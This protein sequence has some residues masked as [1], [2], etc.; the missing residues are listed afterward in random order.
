MSDFSTPQCLFLHLIFSDERNRSLQLRDEAGDLLC[1]SLARFRD[2]CGL[3]VSFISIGKPHHD[4]LDWCGFV[5]RF[6]QVDASGLLAKLIVVA[7]GLLQ[8]SPDRFVN[9]LVHVRLASDLPHEL[10]DRSGLLRDLLLHVTLL[11]HEPAYDVARVLGLQVAQVTLDSLQSTLCLRPR[12]IQLLLPRLL[13]PDLLVE[14][15]ELI[16]GRCQLRPHLLHVT[17][18]IHRE[19]VEAL[20]RVLNTALEAADV[21]L[22]DLPLL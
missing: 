14:L 13:L 21:L 3:E 20:A 15:G 7:A 22:L 6:D 12:L 16:V 4:Q 10:I 19:H 2:I 17:L 9:L 8:G 5:C 11:L 18:A 1:D